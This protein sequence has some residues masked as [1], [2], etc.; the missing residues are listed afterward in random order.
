MHDRHQSR[1]AKQGVCLCTTGG[2]VGAGSTNLEVIHTKRVF[3]AQGLDD[4]P[5]EEMERRQLQGDSNYTISRTNEEDRE[6]TATDIGG[7]PGD[8]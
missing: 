8:R 6:G 5:K 2:Q 4:I 7:T 1:K 3:K